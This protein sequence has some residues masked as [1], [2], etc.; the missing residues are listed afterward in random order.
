MLNK[1]NLESEA[2][3]KEKVDAIRNFKRAKRR[4]QCYRNFNFHR[5]TGIMSQEID[6]IQIPIS[7]KAMEKYEENAEFK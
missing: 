5:G 4:N 2:G 1:A 3:D 7:W 6:R